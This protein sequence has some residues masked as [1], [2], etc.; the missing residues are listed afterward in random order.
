[1]DIGSTHYWLFVGTRSL[2]SDVYSIKNNK[3]FFNVL[4]ETS[5]QREKIVNLSVTKMSLKSKIGYRVFF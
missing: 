2:V 3:N 1:M 4:K 5:V